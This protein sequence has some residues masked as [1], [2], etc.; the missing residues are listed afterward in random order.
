MKTFLLSLLAI[1][2]LTFC[3]RAAAADEPQAPQVR[4]ELFIALLP[5]ARAIELLPDLHDAAKC[6]AAQ[7]QIVA[8]I[9]GKEAEL[10][11]WPVLTT[12]SGQRAVSTNLRQVRYAT[13]YSP[14]KAPKTPSASASGAAD[15]AGKRDTAKAPSV[16]RHGGAMREAFESKDVGITFEVEPTVQA[17]GWHVDMQIAAQHSTL[18][19]WS[20]LAP[21]GGAKNPVTVEQPEFQTLQ[22]STNIVATSGGSVLLGVHKLQDSTRQV[23]VF[24][25]TTTVIKGQ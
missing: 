7:E 20:K 13:A 17:D 12:K 22:T 23:E 8:L 24:I 10:V 6:N 11:D 16:S 9:A 21:E 2:P 25:L 3:Q 5:E 18:L 1:T 15:E 14:V 19:G 4:L